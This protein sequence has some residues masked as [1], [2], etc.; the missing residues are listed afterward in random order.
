MDA[1]LSICSGVYRWAVVAAIQASWFQTRAR[2]DVSR[3]NGGAA[4]ADRWLREETRVA[5]NLKTEPYVMAHCLTRESRMVRSSAWKTIVV[6][7]FSTAARLS[8]KKYYFFITLLPR[9]LSLW[10]ATR[11]SITRRLSQYPLPRTR[12]GRHCTAIRPAAGAFTAYSW[13]TAPSPRS[14]EQN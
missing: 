1:S 13:T 2:H 9:I 12:I 14:L 4:V 5:R 7:N 10:K 6:W 8:C 3:Q 11:D